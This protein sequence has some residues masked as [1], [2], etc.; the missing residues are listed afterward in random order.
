VCAAFGGYLAGWIARRNALSHALALGTIGALA[1]LAIIVAAP[2]TQRS[3]ALYL[4]AVLVIPATALG[5][6]LRG[7]RKA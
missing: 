4:S 2:K 7:E 3:P 1:T 5:G 6:V